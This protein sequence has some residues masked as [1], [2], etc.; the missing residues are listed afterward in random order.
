MVP[1]IALVVFFL[2]AEDVASP[3]ELKT[4]IFQP[5]EMNVYLV[6]SNTFV[7]VIVLSGEFPWPEHDIH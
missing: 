3:A 7:G 6:Q 2:L 4:Q 1:G 5:D